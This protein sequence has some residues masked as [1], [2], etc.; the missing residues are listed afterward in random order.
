MEPNKMSLPGK[1]AA[2]GALLGLA[3]GIFVAVPWGALAAPDN[4]GLWVAFFLVPTFTLMGGWFAT[5]LSLSS[6]DE[7]A[8]EH[9]VHTEE[10]NLFHGHGH[11][12]PA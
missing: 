10:E 8:S 1:R 6:L 5:V 7:A 9:E 3:I 11:P 12:K 4:G 2:V